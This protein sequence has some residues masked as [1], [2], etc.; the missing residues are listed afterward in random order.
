MQEQEVEQA[1]PSEDPDAMRPII[2]KTLGKL[3]PMRSCDITEKMTWF[4][5]Q[6]WKIHIKA[7]ENLACK[8]YDWKACS[9]ISSELHEVNVHATRSS[10]AIPSTSYLYDHSDVL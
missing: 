9:A 1:D 4:D 10:A 5:K 7:L 6:E 2:Q 3:C 8:Y